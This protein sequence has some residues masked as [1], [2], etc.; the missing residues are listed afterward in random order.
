MMRKVGRFVFI[1]L[2]RDLLGNKNLIEIFILPNI[3]FSNFY[4]MEIEAGTMNLEGSS[5]H[6]KPYQNG[7][8]S[9]FSPLSE[10]CPNHSLFTHPVSEFSLEVEASQLTKMMGGIALEEKENE[11]HTTDRF[12]PL[13]KHSP[14]ESNDPFC[15]I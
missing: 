15:C 4:L 14:I 6:P 9:T 10:N 7:T 11:K 1:F 3:L 8:P 13:R 2:I 5:P 12:I